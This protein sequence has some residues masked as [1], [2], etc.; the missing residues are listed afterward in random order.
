MPPTLPGIPWGSGRG[1]ALC[2]LLARG[3][4][5]VSPHRLSWSVCDRPKAGQKCTMLPFH[6]CFASLPWPICSLGHLVLKVISRLLVFC[7]PQAPVSQ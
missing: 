2:P 1:V 6:H 5:G 3:C 7:Q 4:R